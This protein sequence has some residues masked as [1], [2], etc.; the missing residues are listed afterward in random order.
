MKTIFYLFSILFCIPCYL[1]G[2]DDDNTHVTVHVGEHRLSD[3]LTDEQRSSVTH[4]TVTGTL[5]KDDY[6]FLRSYVLGHLDELNLR[7]TDIDT[8]PEGALKYMKD[9]S[10]IVLPFNI[11]HLEE[12]SVVFD[13]I[14]GTIEVSG[15]YP[16][17]GKNFFCGFD[18]SKDNP[19]CRRVDS[20]VAIYG[21]SYS[22]YSIDGE[23]LYYKND[24]EKSGKNTYW[25]KV[26]EG[27]KRINATTCRSQII[28]NNFNFVFPESLESIGDYAF[29]GL[30]VVF[31]T[32]STKSS[33]SSYY[34]P[35]GSQVASIICEAINP[36][37]LGVGVFD[38]VFDNGY[39]ENFDVFELYVPEESIDKYRNAKGWRNFKSLHSIE[40]LIEFGG[41]PDFIKNIKFSSTESSC[42]LTFSRP[43]RCLYIYNLQ[44]MLLK[45]I[46]VNSTC[47]TI[48]K[49]LL[50]L[51]YALVRVQ[52]G[53]GDVETLKLKP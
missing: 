2:Q 37:V 6:A 16:T 49:T 5:E 7:D 24:I 14:D 36:S 39:S 45:S 52:Y 47:A 3:L 38:G 33:S 1:Y 12:N 44:G 10:R 32:C 43:V 8:I 11:K 48:D 22:I 26:A 29:E 18:V 15:N 13:Y 40:W 41:Y 42:V 23:T 53:N 34:Y 4:L 20:S 31:P 21:G 27:T 19:Y 30:S 17:C 9:F 46:D 50:S 51:P 25:W 28:D 35:N